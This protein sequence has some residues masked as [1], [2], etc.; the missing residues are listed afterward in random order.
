MEQFYNGLRENKKGTDCYPPPSM[1][2]TFFMPM[3]VL[4]LRIEVQII[5]KNCY[6]T[7]FSKELHDKIASKLINDLITQL[8]D[9]NIF[10]SRFSFFE[11]GL[12][13]INIKYERNKASSIDVARNKFFT[14]SALMQ[15]LIPNPS[16][17]KVGALYGTG[18][19][20]ILTK[21]ALQT[22]KQVNPEQAQAKLAESSVC[23][24]QEHQEVEKKPEAVVEKITKIP[25]FLREQYPPREG[26]RTA[27]EGTR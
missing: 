24:K 6:P 11:S 10:Y 9:P 25:T 20:A 3:I 23:V 21:M 27:N 2:H 26:L 14:R 19:Q 1:F 13:A 17:G 8:V 5:F 12:D 22:M 18:K 16:E 15:Q 4:A 7:F